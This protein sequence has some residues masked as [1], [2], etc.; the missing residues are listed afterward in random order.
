MLE[1]EKA[2]SEIK[3][4]QVMSGCYRAFTDTQDLAGCSPGRKV[5]GFGH[6]GWNLRE[7]GWHQMVGCI[8]GGVEVDNP[9]QPVMC[10]FELEMLQVGTGWVLEEQEVVTGQKTQGQTQEHQQPER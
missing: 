1:T 7:E 10:S 9:L 2:P 4:S 5:D 8:Q 3:L 6:R